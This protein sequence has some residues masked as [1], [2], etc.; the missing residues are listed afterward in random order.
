MKIGNQIW[1]QSESLSKLSVRNG[2]KYLQI[3]NVLNDFQVREPWH[4]FKKSIKFEREYL[5]LHILMQQG[6]EIRGWNMYFIS[7][8]ANQ[9]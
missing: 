7:F 8:Q 9:K 4:I 1:H 2:A 5:N 6:H 3:P